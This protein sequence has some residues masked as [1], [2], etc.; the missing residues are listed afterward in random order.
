MADEP[1]EE[2]RRNGPYGAL[3]HLRLQHLPPRAEPVFE[4]PAMQ[5]RVWGNVWGVHNDVGRLRLCLVH[6]PADEM[7]IIDPGKYDPSLDALIDRDLQWMYGGSTP[8]DIAK[9]QEQHD[10]LVRALEAE[11]V[12]VINIEMPPLDPQA[13][14]PRDAAVAVKGGAIVCRLGP[15]GDQPGSG[16]RGEEAYVTK[17][18]AALG[19]PILH[20]IHGAGLM[21]GGSFLFVNETTAVLGVG[22][23][24]NEAAA[25]QLEAVFNEQ[26]VRL[27][28]VPITGYSQHIDGS[29]VMVDYDKAI[30]HVARLPYWFLEELE[31]LGIQVIQVWPGENNKP[32]NC[33]AVRPGRVIIAEGC[34]REVKALNAAGVET[35]EIP[36]DAI[37]RNGGGIHC[38]T[39]PLVRDP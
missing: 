38:A 16:R 36:F 37:H 4:D 39:L 2:L 1:D 31:R 7:A 21:E 29:I 30:A 10:G 22:T 6:R 35:I 3:Y 20:T 26:G 28:R 13:M 12:Q 27:L 9:M 15:V 14:F 18:I 19:M 5:R 24:Q 11:D 17:A 23:R 32:V 8:P 25:R 33:L 34:P